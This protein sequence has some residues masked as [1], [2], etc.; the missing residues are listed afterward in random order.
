MGTQRQADAHRDGHMT[1]EAEVGA[2]QLQECQGFPVLPEARR[3][4]EGLSLEPPSLWGFE[5]TAPG[6]E[7]SH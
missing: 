1:A 4:K 6:N 3:S 5:M 7:Y 2:I